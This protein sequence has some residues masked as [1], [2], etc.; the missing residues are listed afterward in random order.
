MKKTILLFLIAG[1]LISVSLN[2][3]KQEVRANLGLL[4]TSDFGDVFSDLI[5]NVISGENYSSKNSTS[6]GALGIE[7]WHNQGKVLKLGGLF[8]YQSIKK[9]IYTLGDKVGNVNDNY[10]T[11]LPEISFEYVKAEWV[12]VYSGLGL[13]VTILNQVFNSS[14]SDLESSSESNVLLN[15]HLNLVGMRVGKA[16][17]ASAELGVGAKGIFNAGLSYRF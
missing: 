14:V 9:D 13:G 3:Q 4:T 5:I 15:F 7:Y 12:Q 8:S 2:A 17:G 1:M 11:I 16:F 6:T 10:F